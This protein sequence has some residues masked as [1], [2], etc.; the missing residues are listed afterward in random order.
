MDVDAARHHDH[1]SRVDSRR[2]CREVGDDTTVGAAYIANFSVD[3][4][5]GVVDR[6]ARDAE[7]T[8]LLGRALGGKVGALAVNDDGRRVRPAG[9]ASS[10]GAQSAFGRQD[11]TPELIRQVLGHLADRV[12]GRLRAKERAGRTV[13]VRVRFAGMRSVTRSHT[14]SRPMSTI[15]TVTDLAERLVHAALAL[16][17]GDPL[18]DLAFSAFPYH[19]GASGAAVL[20]GMGPDSGIPSERNYIRAYCRRTG[21]DGIEGWNYYLAFGMF[22]LASIMQGVYQRV[23]KGNVASDFAA[24]NQ[25]PGM[26]RQALAMLD[27]RRL[28]EIF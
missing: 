18:A 6:A 24:V 3:T 23:L 14:S 15:L 26:A 12:T 1:A 8:S 2:R 11:P 4:V 16:W 28:Q 27:D 7:L 20:D 25:A 17:R 21:R 9:R 5:R 19:R 22:R 13:T 10:V